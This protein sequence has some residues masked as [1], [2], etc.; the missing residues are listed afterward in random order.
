MS[1]LDSIKEKIVDFLEDFIATDFEGEIIYALHHYIPEYDPDWAP[2]DENPY[3]SEAKRT[4]VARRRYAKALADEL[5]QDA[6][7]EE[8]G[9]F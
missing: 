2:Y 6:E 1:K 4:N 5:M 3:S 8:E 9:S 7:L